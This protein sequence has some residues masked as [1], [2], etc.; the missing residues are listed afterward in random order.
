MIKKAEDGRPHQARGKRYC[1]QARGQIFINRL[2]LI[3]KYN[4]G[5]EGIDMLDGIV[6]LYR[7]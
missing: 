5:I 2:H 7:C 4:E 6:A 1:K 3:A